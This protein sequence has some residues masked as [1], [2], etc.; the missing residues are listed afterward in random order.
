MTIIDLQT[1]RL[2]ALDHPVFFGTGHLQGVETD[3]HQYPGDGDM[4]H[5]L[6]A[7]TWLKAGEQ[8]LELRNHVLHWRS[9]STILMAYLFADSEGLLFGALF[10]TKRVGGLIE[11]PR[12]DPRGVVADVWGI[13][14]NL[15]TFMAW[16]KEYERG[17]VERPAALSE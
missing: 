14:S 6:P 4:M 9:D 16:L 11:V 15:Q 17:R 1:N 7:K 12:A 5:W 3:G 8:R 10:T 2:A 13:F